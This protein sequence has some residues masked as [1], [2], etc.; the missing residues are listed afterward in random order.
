[1]I[2]NSGE[3]KNF[4]ENYIPRIKTT[5]HFVGKNIF[6]K[7]TLIQGFSGFLGQNRQLHGIPGF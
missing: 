4:V 3:E 5:F 6:A 7:K 1:M 2:I